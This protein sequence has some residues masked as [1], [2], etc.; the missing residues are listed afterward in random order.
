MVRI[1][2]G[3]PDRTGARDQ[4]P[5][6]FLLPGTRVRPYPA[7]AVAMSEQAKVAELVVAMALGASAVRLGGSCPPFCT[8]AVVISAV[9][10][11]SWPAK[12]WQ[13]GAESARLS[14]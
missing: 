9:G 6:P 13:R 4:S 14:R 11:L 3:P 10:A 2:H 12:D 8:I 5:A 1:H 7:I